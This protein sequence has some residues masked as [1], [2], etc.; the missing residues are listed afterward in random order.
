MGFDILTYQNYIDFFGSF[1]NEEL[2]QLSDFFQ[3]LKY[4][5]SQDIQASTYFYLA[6]IAYQLGNNNLSFSYITEFS[7]LMPD[8]ISTFIVLGNIYYNQ[9]K[10]INAL[11]LNEL[12]KLK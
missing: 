10:Y 8:E 9:K 7:R 6:I 12:K 1:N 5:D 4:S 11:L 3:I 2:T